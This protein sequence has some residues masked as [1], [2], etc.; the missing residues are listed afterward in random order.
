MFKQQQQFFLQV[1]ERQQNQQQMFQQTV[2]MMLD[3]YRSGREEVQR[4]N[5]AR[6]SA[7]EARSDPPPGYALSYSAKRPLLSAPSPR[8]K[9]ARSKSPRNSASPK[10]ANSL[11]PPVPCLP[12]QIQELKAEDKA[13]IDE[14]MKI[15]EVIML[16]TML[17]TLGPCSTGVWGTSPFSFLDVPGYGLCLFFPKRHDALMRKL[18]FKRP[19]ARKRK[20][21]S[22]KKFVDAILAKF[23]VVDLNCI[24]LCVRRIARFCQV[25][26]P[27]KNENNLDEFIVMTLANAAY[28]MRQVLARDAP[29]RQPLRVETYLF[30]KG[31]PTRSAFSVK[32]RDGSDTKSFP[33]ADLTPSQLC[34]TV[35]AEWKLDSDLP[36]SSLTL[37]SRKR[38]FFWLAQKKFYNAE[39]AEPLNPHWRRAVG[40]IRQQVFHLETKE[41]LFHVYPDTD[42]PYG[43][44]V[45]ATDTIPTFPERYLNHLR[46]HEHLFGYSPQ[47]AQPLFDIEPPVPPP[48]PPPPPQGFSSSSSCASQ[49]LWSAHGGTPGPFILPPGGTLSSSSTISSSS[50]SSSGME[51]PGPPR[52]YFVPTQAPSPIE[53]YSVLGLHPLLGP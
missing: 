23:P 34:A 42:S 2:M 49:G 12:V 25:V 36:L 9:K 1:M 8:S 45:Q 50:S 48:P 4:K 31:S 35:R 30:K 17:L 10:P 11:F 20:T 47:E 33:I 32:L 41:T 26:V 16:G 7:L 14:S 19:G 52:E 27:Y 28:L 18:F 13:K 5:E 53:N 15:R 40:Y 22:A 6:L 24:P 3:E 43:W 29:L 44:H 46:G 38:L 21:Q 37:E 51:L 39:S